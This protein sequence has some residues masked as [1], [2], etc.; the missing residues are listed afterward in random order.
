[1]KGWRDQGGWGSESLE[2]IRGEGVPPMD[3]CPA[4]SSRYD[5]PEVKAAAAANR[6]TEWW[7]G[8]D[9]RDTNRQIMVSCFLLGLPPVLDLDWMGHSMCGAELDSINPLRAFTDN[10]WGESAGEKGLY[11]LEGSKAIPD[12]LVIPRVATA[13]VT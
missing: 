7:D 1:V 2:K 13:A 5:T 9:D 4:Y 11:R 8:T 3:L 6:V 12:G 10:S